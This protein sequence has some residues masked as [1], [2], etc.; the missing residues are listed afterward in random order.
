M[1]AWWWAARRC[2]WRLPLSVQP[3]LPVWVRPSFIVWFP[4]AGGRERVWSVRH[5]IRGSAGCVGGVRPRGSRG[6]RWGWGGVGLSVV[7]CPPACAPCCPPLRPVTLRHGP[8]FFHIPGSSAVSCSRVVSL[9]VPH[10]CGRFPVTLGPSSPPC[11]GAPS[12]PLPSPCLCPFPSRCGGGGVGGGLWGADGPR[13]GVGGLE[14]LA[15]G[16]G[17][18]CRGG[19]VPGPRPGGGLPMGPAA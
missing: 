15:E 18:G 6:V 2:F 11:R 10:P 16:L 4:V 8:C 13:L 19:A 1:R 12:R 14:P 3:L 9:P 17:L 7:A 5:L